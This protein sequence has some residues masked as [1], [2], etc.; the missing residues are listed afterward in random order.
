M[1]EYAQFTPADAHPMAAA[2]AGRV[3][4]VREIPA[5][6][7]MGDVRMFEVRSVRT[8]AGTDAFLDEL[9]WED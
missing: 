8:G 7:I 4:I 2:I 1:A 5:D 3:E 6:E 9:T